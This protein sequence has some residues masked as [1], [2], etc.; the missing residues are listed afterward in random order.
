MPSTQVKRTC[1]TTRRAEV[2]AV[3]RHHAVRLAVGGD[4]NL[5]DLGFG[6]LQQPVAMA[7]QGVAALVD[8]DAF[9]ERHRAL[10]EPPDDAFEFLESLFE[11]CALT[12]ALVAMVVV[13]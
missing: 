5:L 7:A 12:S 3:E 2:T 10:L 13:P 1:G 8:G 11:A 4:A 9:L 6:S